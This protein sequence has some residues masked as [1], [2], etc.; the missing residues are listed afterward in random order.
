MGAVNDFIERITTVPGTH[1]RLELQDQARRQ[2]DAY[3]SQL[4]A[5][6]DLVAKEKKS[7]D[8]QAQFRQNKLNSQIRRGNRSRIRGGIFGEE[9]QNS[10]GMLSGRLG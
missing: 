5:Q 6:R 4:N 3:N 2:A 1:R 9:N 7:L 8:E 10:P